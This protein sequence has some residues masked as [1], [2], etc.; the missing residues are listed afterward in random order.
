LCRGSRLIPPGLI[1]EGS[2]A[3]QEGAALAMLDKI[4]KI[5]QGED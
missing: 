1:K 5:Y 4:I 3:C 2:G